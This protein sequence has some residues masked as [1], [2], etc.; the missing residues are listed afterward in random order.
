MVKNLVFGGRCTGLLAKYDPG[1]SCWKTS[2]RSLIEDR[3]WETFCGRWPSWG[4]MWSCAVFRLL[5]SGLPTE[6]RGGFLLPTPIRS[7]ATHRP[8]NSLSRL[9]ESGE[10]YS[11]GDK[12]ITLP[13]PT[14]GAEQ[15]TRYSQGGRSTMCGILEAIQTTGKTIGKDSRLN[16][17]FV[18]EMMGFPIAWLD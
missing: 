4:M 11:P 10:K 12:R 8:T 2:Q 13:T 17:H 3:G 6:D 16:P 14:T 18:T 9:V 7:D 1:S 15:R 5:P